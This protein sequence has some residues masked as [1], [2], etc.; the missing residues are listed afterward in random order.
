MKLTQHLRE[1]KSLENAKNDEQ[2][3]QCETLWHWIAHWGMVWRRTRTLRSIFSKRLWKRWLHL[4]C[5]FLNLVRSNSNAIVWNLVLENSWV[6]WLL[7]TV[8]KFGIHPE[9][10][11]TNGSYDWRWMWNNNKINFFERCKRKKRH[12]CPTITWQPLLAT[13]TTHI[14]FATS[15]MPPNVLCTLNEI[16][17]E[18]FGNKLLVDDIHVNKYLFCQSFS[19]E[20]SAHAK[21]T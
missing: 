7:W 9:N 14:Q 3:N 8:S 13:W 15:R 11:S 5:R 17:V 1:I 6:R 20:V 12:L 4:L 21:N 19:L 10:C 2:C 16:C 18:T